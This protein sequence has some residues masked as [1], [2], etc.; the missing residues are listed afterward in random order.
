M[1]AWNP[2]GKKS[3]S[4]TQR[5]LLGQGLVDHLEDRKMEMSFTQLQELEDNAKK[6]YK[7]VKRY[8][9]CVMQMH[10][11]EQKMSSELCNQENEDLRKMAE[12]YQSVVYQ[13]NHTTE[14]LS[15]LSKKTVVEPLKKLTGEFESVANAVKKRDATLT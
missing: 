4:L 14:D 9:E 11:L 13:M 2:L 7:E 8:E 15:H 6:L 12:D 1:M 3:A 10:K 5:P